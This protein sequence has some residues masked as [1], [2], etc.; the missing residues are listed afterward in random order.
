MDYFADGVNR[1]ALC[2]V[3]SA[4][5]SRRLPCYRYGAGNPLL[6]RHRARAERVGAVPNLG[7]YR[8]S[9]REREREREK[10]REEEEEEDRER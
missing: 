5:T 8:E 2:M 3:A 10:K 4:R 9:E 1:P 6:T 7:W